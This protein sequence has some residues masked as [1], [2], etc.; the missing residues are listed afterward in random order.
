MYFARCGPDSPQLVDGN[1]II[2][3]YE[4]QL[5]KQDTQ[6]GKDIDMKRCFVAEGRELN[7]SRRGGSDC[8]VS[9]CLL[10]LTGCMQ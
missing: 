10:Q 4:H 6:E 9:L 1:D 5:H 2:R 8:K 7:G 3:T